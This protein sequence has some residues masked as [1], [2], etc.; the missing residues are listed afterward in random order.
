MTPE[1]A[2]ALE[3]AI[4]QIDRQ[5]G[6]GAVMRLGDVKA[7]TGTQAISTGSI[8][9]ELAL[10]I[11]GIPKGRVTEAFG[12]ESSGKST[13]AY[14]VM[15]SAQKAGGTAAYIDAEHALDPGYA[16]TCGLDAKELLEM[17]SLDAS[18]ALGG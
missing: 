14:H 3:L 11:G 17:V 7:E 2:K 1:K 12:T 15:A 5:F 13:L 4:G 18:R 10:G 9:L 6:H 16:A 8:S